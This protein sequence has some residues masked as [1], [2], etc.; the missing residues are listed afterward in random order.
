MLAWHL[1]LTNVILQSWEAPNLLSYLLW[2]LSLIYRL[3]FALRRIA[4]KLN[5][6]KS[7]RAPVPIIVVGTNITVGG[8]G[9]TPMVIYLIEQ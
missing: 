4:Y 5:L 8:T 6:L 3:V 2:P 1:K 7:Y 9:K